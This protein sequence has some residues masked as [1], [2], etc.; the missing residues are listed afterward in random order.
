VDFESHK[1]P[2]GVPSRIDIVYN[3]EKRCW[4]GEEVLS[5]NLLDFAPAQLR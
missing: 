3:L 4:G 5:L 1:K 2:E